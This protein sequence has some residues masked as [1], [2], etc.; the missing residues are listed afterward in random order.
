MLRLLH[1]KL[2]LRRRQWCVRR[3]QHVPRVAA[4]GAVRGLRQHV[5]Q[6][7]LPR[8]L[9]QGGARPQLHPHDSLL[10]GHGRLGREGHGVLHLHNAHRHAALLLL[11]HREQQGPSSSLKLL[12]L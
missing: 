2:L 1:H 11:L 8:V 4:P 9:L 6:R 10:L 12:R 3:R 7:Q 5:L